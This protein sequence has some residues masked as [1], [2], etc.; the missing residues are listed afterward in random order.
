MRD[1]GSRRKLSSDAQDLRVNTM[2]TARCSSPH[3]AT[4]VICSTNSPLGLSDKV[5]RQCQSGP[6]DAG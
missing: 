3:G 2:R 5:V 6:P 1:G 4:F